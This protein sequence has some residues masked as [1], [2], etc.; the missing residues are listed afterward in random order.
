[1]TAAIMVESTSE[2]STECH[3]LSKK[4]MGKI[5]NFNPSQYWASGASTK[6]GTETPSTARNAAPLSQILFCLGAYDAEKQP[7]HKPDYDRLGPQEK[8]D[9]KPLKDDVRHG[10][11]P[12]LVRG[13][14]VP[15][16]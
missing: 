2:G 7:H 13:A 5:P 4:A 3:Q 16:E 11:T 1:M 8:G 12:E 6:S 14:E 9:G 15:T 10:P